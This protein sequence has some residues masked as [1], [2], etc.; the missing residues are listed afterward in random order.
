MDKNV[1]GW[2]EIPV[3]D[4]NRAIKFYET[5]F[6]FKIDRHE[7]GPLDMGW[8]PMI[9]EGM[10]SPGS[11]VKHEEWYK[12]STEGALL[13]FTSQSGDVDVELGR[14]EAAGGKVLVPRKQISEEY[15]YM[16]VIMDTEGNRIAV[17]SRK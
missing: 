12:P 16:G 14:V 6:G 5:V 17:H 10:G 3:A 11:L 8:F 9:E 2:F 7:M 13:Y 15:D 1:V 4:M